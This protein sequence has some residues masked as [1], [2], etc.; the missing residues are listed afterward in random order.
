MRTIDEIGLAL[1]ESLKDLR[2]RRNVDRVSLAER[3]G[4][5]LTALKNL[6]AGGGTIKTLISV[7][8]ALGREEWFNTIAPLASVNPLTMPRDAERRQ[9]ASKPRK[10][11]EKKEPQ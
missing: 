2:L 7:V 10:P 8:R 1:G 3:A 6:E 11:R 5:S 4:V 9:R